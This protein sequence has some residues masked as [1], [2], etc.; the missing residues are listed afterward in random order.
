MKNKNIDRESMVNKKLRAPSKYRM[1]K[2]LESIIKAVNLEKR[3]DRSPV[4]T[5]SKDA[6]RWLDSV[7]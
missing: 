7:K 4:F 3:S 5:N 2:Y 1:T 6:I